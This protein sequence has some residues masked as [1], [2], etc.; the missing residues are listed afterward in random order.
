V[1]IF[2]PSCKMNPAFGTE[3]RRIHPPGGFPEEFQEFV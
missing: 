2:E 1:L 3:G